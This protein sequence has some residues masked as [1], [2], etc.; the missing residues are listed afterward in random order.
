MGV[1]SHNPYR[2]DGGAGLDSPTGANAARLLYPPGAARG[3]TAVTS[4]QPSGAASDL[5]PPPRGSYHAPPRPLPSPPPQGAGSAARARCE[6]HTAMTPTA[7]APNPA[8]LELA[9][10]SD[11]VERTLGDVGVAKAPNRTSRKPVRCGS[12]HHESA[13]GRRG[14]GAC[15][16]TRGRAWRMR[17]K[18][19]RPPPKKTYAAPNR[20]FVS[21]AGGDGRRA[22]P[23]S[24]TAAA[25]TADARRGAAARPQRPMP[26]TFRAQKRRKVAAPPPRAVD[27]P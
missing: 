14:D 17:G 5:P 19:C 6:A 20:Q 8:V 15:A 1:R 4:Q 13:A 10:H 25:A 3:E 27:L 11:R 22:V 12:A 7:P 23:R 2:G 18:Y 24:A 21:P 9:H 16:A 26:P